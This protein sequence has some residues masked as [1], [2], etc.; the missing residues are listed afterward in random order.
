MLAKPSNS[1]HSW[2]IFKNL[3]WPWIYY[4]LGK[5]WCSA[6]CSLDEAFDYLLLCSE[7]RLNCGTVRSFLIALHCTESAHESCDA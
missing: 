4:V 1:N 6:Y 2:G 3:F 5:D 7:T